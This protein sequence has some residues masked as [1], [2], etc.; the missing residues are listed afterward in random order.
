MR[1]LLTLFTLIFAIGVT[2][3]AFDAEARKM[4]GGRSMGKSYKTAP[5]QPAK[6]Q[7]AGQN[8]AGQTQTPKKSG[9]LMG[10]LLGGLLAGGLIA[11]LMGSGAFEGFQIMDFL[12]IAGL[13]F[14]AFKI[15]GALRKGK[16][17][18]QPPLTAYSGPQQ[19]EAPKEQPLTSSSPTAVASGFAASDVPFNL[20]PNFDMQ[21]FLQGSREHYRTLQEAWNK[22]DLEKI[23][24]YVT[25]E[26]FADLSKERATLSGEQHTEVM[27]VDAELVRADHTSYH[28]QV[29][30]KFSG[31]YRDSQEGVEQDIKEVWHLERDLTKENAPWLIVGLEDEAS[32]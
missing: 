22:D 28:A 8:T 18:A 30:L 27:F 10:G 32:A 20:P 2:A 17:Q 5:A 6:Q 19:F 9:G 25:P 11:A 24:E 15:F 4:G 23:R 12:M 1:K 31:R 14:V 7:T 21:A 13:A 16:A 26:L 3:T 29:S